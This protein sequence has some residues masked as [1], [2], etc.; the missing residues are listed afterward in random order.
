M[1]TLLKQSN[2]ITNMGHNL[3]EVGEQKGGTDVS[4]FRLTI[5]KKTK[6]N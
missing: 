2:C 5:Y 4:N 1:K 6:T 3:T